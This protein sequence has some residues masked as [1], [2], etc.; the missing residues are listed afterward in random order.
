MPKRVDENIIVL[1]QEDLRSGW[2]PKMIELG[3]SAEI[4]KAPFYISLSNELRHQRYGLI[5]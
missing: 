3:L 4:R 1:A 2:D 5:N